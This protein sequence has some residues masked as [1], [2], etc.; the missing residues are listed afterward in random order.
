M[1]RG[2]VTCCDLRFAPGAEALLRSVRKHH[3]DVRCCCYVPPEELHEISLRLGS[4]AEV[5]P[6]VLPINALPKTLHMLF[7]RILAVTRKEDV[8]GYVDSDALFCR[9]APELWDVQPG[10]LNA[11]ED[12]SQ[13]IS[14]ILKGEAKQAFEAQFPDAGSSRGFNTGVFAL[15][16]AE[17]QDLLQRLKAILTVEPYGPVYIR[18][19]Q[20]PSIGLSDQP[21]LNVLMRGRVRYL[22]RIFNAHCLYDNPIP[23]DVRIV[24]FTS[25]PKPWMRSFRAHEPAYWYWL[26]YGLPE[27]GPLRLALAALWIA[28]VSPKRML[29]RKWRKCIRRIRASAAGNS[30]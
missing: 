27:A 4:L 10:F 11:V 20:D 5:Q 3:P 16:P 6:C 12:E 2:L 18:A 22:P 1:T 14:D 24:H 19:A 23:P 29:G 7:G 13:R 9:P 25:L 17:W 26:K 21:L 28:F 8:V 30:V 15:R